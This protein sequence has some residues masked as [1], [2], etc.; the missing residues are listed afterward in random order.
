MWLIFARNIC[1]FAKTV[2]LWDINMHI[3]YIIIIH[4][5]LVAI[6]KLC[7]ITMTLIQLVI[8]VY[9]QKLIIT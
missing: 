4:N 7:M 2:I 8:I 1:F 9:V 5:Y 3:L 6:L